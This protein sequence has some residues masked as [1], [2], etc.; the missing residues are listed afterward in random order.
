MPRPAHFEIHTEDPDRAISFYTALFDW[1]FEKWDGPL[2]Y[3]LIMTGP[4]NEPGINGGLVRRHGTR[5]AVG[6]PVNA[7]PCTIMVPALDTLMARLIQLGGTVAL[8]KMAVP[9]VGWLGYGIDLDG[10]IFGM[11]Q[12]DLTAE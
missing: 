3:W 7:F 2:D 12:A 6:Q 4:D 8:P 5:P 11:M 10:N 9:G 1:K